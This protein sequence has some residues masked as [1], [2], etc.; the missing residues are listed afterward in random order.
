MV[1]LVRVDDEVAILTIDLKS[2]VA[3]RNLVLPV[4]SKNSGNACRLVSWISSEWNQP[5]ESAMDTQ[6]G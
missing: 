4:S 6:F 3:V 1:L 5:V 2:H